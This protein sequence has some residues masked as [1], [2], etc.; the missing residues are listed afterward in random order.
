[1]ASFMAQESLNASAESRLAFRELGLAI[2]LHAVSVMQSLLESDHATAVNDTTRELV[3]DL[4][5]AAPVGTAIETF[6][7]APE[8]RNAYSWQ[9][10][11]DIN[12]VMLATSLVPDGFLRLR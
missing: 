4:V 2:G 6:W 7:R 11:E 3:K 9:A 5:K 1:L 12:M 8:N 10:H